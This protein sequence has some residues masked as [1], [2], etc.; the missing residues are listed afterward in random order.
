MATG[1]YPSHRPPKE[2]APPGCSGLPGHAQPCPQQWLVLHTRHPHGP[3]S[4]CKCPCQWRWWHRCSGGDWFT[5]SKIQCHRLFILLQPRWKGVVK[6][7]GKQTAPVSVGV[8]NAQ[9]IRLLVHQISAAPQSHICLL[10]SLLKQTQCLS[11]VR[12]VSEVRCYWVKSME[13]VWK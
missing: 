12:A 5:S 6:Q 7:Q 2:A 1:T 9:K 8:L 11:K 13:S 3:C 10:S 4:H